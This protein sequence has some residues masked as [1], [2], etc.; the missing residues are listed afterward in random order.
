MP[1]NVDAVIRYQF[2]V[3][4]WIGIGGSSAKSAHFEAGVS[5]GQII[6]SDTDVRIG[7]SIDRFFND[8]G[9]NFGST[10]EVG[11]SWL[12][13]GGFQQGEVSEN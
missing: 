8:V 5:V 3:P 11:I 2:K 9:P 4:F 6:Q 7:Y 1:F 12:F 13:G 10:H